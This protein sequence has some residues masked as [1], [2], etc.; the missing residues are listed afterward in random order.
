MVYLSEVLTELGYTSSE[1]EA[2]RF[3]EGGIIFLDGKVC[4]D[5]MIEVFGAHRIERRGRVSIDEMVVV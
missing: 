5:P 3:I 4:R 2:R 1:K